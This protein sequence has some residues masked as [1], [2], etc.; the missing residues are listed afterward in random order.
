MAEHITG[1]AKA[2]D[3]TDHTAALT[4]LQLKD[5]NTGKKRKRET[6]WT[7]KRAYR[8]TFFHALE[9]VVRPTDLNLCANAA[10]RLQEGSKGAM[11]GFGQCCMDGRRK[12]GLGIGPSAKKETT[13]GERPYSSSYTGTIARDKGLVAFLF[14]FMSTLCKKLF[15]RLAR[16]MRELAMPM[17]YLPPYYTCGKDPGRIICDSGV[18]G[19]NLGNLDHI[20]M[21][22]SESFSVWVSNDVDNKRKARRSW[23]LMFPNIQLENG[24]CLGIRLGHGVFVKWN[25]RLFRH[26]TTVLPQDN[27]GARRFSPF[28]SVGQKLA[29][30]RKNNQE[31]FRGRGDVQ[32]REG[33]VSIRRNSIL[34]N[35][36]SKAKKV[37]DMQEKRAR[38]GEMYGTLCSS[39]CTTMTQKLKGEQLVHSHVH[40]P[41]QPHTHMVVDG[42]LKKLLG[43][44]DQCRTLYRNYLITSYAWTR[45]KMA[46]WSREK[47]DIVRFVRMEMEEGSLKHTQVLDPLCDV[48]NYNVHVKTITGDIR[49]ISCGAVQL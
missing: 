34:Q 23:L 17:G 36:I 8:R 26:A 2:Q 39:T 20:D 32:E 16:K 37:Q 19:Y 30:F 40:T 21:D 45:R 27:L 33:K 24:K 41:I 9:A 31:G 12:V 47:N 49:I 48:C 35:S 28:L 22:A 25:G 18:I 4:L 46:K 44:D 13:T 1:V 43:T 3:G 29:R 7:R 11:V 14:C 5:C 42:K 15:P 6:P 10:V 38:E